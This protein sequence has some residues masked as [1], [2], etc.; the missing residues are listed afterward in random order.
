MNWLKKFEKEVCNKCKNKIDNPC[1][2][3]DDCKIKYLKKQLNKYR[4]FI[5]PLKDYEYCRE[6]SPQDL[7][8][9]AQETK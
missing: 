5:N 8:K 4:R 1:I 9:K 2:F 6:I 3:E 7:C